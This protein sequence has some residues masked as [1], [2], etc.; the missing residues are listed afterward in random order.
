MQIQ[1]PLPRLSV[2]TVFEDGDD[3]VESSGIAEAGKDKSRVSALE[4]VVNCQPR[5]QFG[6]DATIVGRYQGFGDF[7]LQPEDVRIFKPLEQILGSSM[8]LCRRRSAEDWQ[9]QARA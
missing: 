6:E 8:F 4:P 7:E 9:K 5:L 2:R 1:T 3:C